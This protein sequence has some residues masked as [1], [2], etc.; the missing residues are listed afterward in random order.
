MVSRYLPGRN[1]SPMW[2]AATSDES[3]GA[4][5]ERYRWRP[6][7]TLSKTAYEVSTSVQASAEN[8]LSGPAGPFSFAPLLDC[9]IQILAPSL[10]SH[11]PRP[12]TPAPPPAAPILPATLSP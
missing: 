12:D 2:N 9:S 3:V 8:T 6:S 10:S 4:E 1:P 7:T 11:F 5:N